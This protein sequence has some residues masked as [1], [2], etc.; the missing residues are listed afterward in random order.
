MQNKYL[1]EN[2]LALVCARG[3]SKGLKGKNFTLL[4]K[5]PL[6]SF[7]ICKI[8]KN[9]LKY[10]CLS[11]DSKKIVKISEKYGLKSFLLDQKNFQHQMSQN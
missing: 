11:T 9:K 3:G 8:L 10:N 4:N 7:A 5:K 2:T 6:I 1:I